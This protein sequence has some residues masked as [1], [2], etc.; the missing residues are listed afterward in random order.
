MFLTISI[1]D[2]F[3]QETL[4]TLFTVMAMPQSQSCHPRQKKR[5][6]LDPNHQACSAC[7]TRKVRC[8]AATPRCLYCAQH[9][10]VC[11][12]PPMYRR[13]TCSQACVLPDLRISSTRGSGSYLTKHL[14]I[15]MWM[16][17]RRESVTARICWHHSR[18]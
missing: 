7:K 8:D 14:R 6:T 1:P 3:A 13:A 5:K 16:S 4:L 15:G 10:K 12:Y 18:A 17:S 11:V 9:D 2:L